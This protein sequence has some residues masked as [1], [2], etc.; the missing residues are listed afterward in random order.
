MAAACEKLNCVKKGKGDVSYEIPVFDFLSIIVQFWES[1]DEFDASL[2]ILVDKNVLQFMR[3][4]TMW[5]AVDHMLDRIKE[6]M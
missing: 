1:D 2:Q 4:E 3:Y 5:Y 6:E